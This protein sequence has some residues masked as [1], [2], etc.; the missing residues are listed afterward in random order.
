[1]FYIPRVRVYRAAAVTSQEMA[2]DTII[3]LPAEIIVYI[4][5]DRQLGFSDVINFSSTCKHLY[6]IVRNN[7]NNKLWERKFFQRYVYFAWK[8]ERV[9]FK[10]KK[11]WA[12]T[13]RTV[14]IQSVVTSFYPACRE[15]PANTVVKQVASLFHVYIVGLFNARRRLLFLF[16][17]RALFQEASV[18]DAFCYLISWREILI[19][20]F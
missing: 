14:D 13:R 20:M 3:S 16:D 17:I 11:S 18:V 6:K 4:L 12:I 2:S 8:G 15:I 1:M 9:A 10:S 5:E 7:N 19:A